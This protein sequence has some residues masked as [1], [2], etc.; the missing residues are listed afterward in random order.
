MTKCLLQGIHCAGWEQE[1]ILVFRVVAVQ[2]NENA[3]I[4][5]Q[6]I[7]SL[8]DSCCLYNCSSQKGLLLFQCISNLY[9]LQR[10]TSVTGSELFH[11]ALA[12]EGTDEM[13][14]D[15]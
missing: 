3:R 13:A 1:I 6:I 10:M 8:P 12:E 11:L 2:H 15:R 7:S 5:R 4:F 14:H 9:S